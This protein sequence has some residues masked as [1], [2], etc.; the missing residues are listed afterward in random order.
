MTRLKGVL[1]SERKATLAPRLVQTLIPQEIDPVI[2][3][4]TT[5]TDFLFNELKV[6]TKLGIRSR[7]QLLGTT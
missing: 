4:Y 5:A 6:L 3:I 7:R 1:S 2:E